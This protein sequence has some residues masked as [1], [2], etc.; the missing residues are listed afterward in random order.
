MVDMCILVCHELVVILF[1]Q[2]IQL[3]ETQEQSSILLMLI[4]QKKL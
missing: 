3:S 1:E 4:S 2:V